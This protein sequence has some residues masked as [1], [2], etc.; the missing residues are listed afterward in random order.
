LIV[1]HRPP[2][3]QT[4]RSERE[5]RTLLNKQPERAA[6]ALLAVED[7]GRDTP[8]ELRHLLGLLT[9][10]HAEPALAPQPGLGQLVAAVRL[11]AAGDALRAASVTRRLVER[12]AAPAPPGPPVVAGSAELATLTARSARCR[13]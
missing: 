12:F 5:A 1:V 4:E 2:R 10:E 13:C 7:S 8:R 9:E 3:A 11:V 6:E